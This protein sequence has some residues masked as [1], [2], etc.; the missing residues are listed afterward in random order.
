V[1]NHDELIMAL[2]ELQKQN[3]QVIMILTAAQNSCPFMHV[4]GTLKVT[5]CEI[6]EFMV[7]EAV[8]RADTVCREQIVRGV[9]DIKEIS[10]WMNHVYKGSPLMNGVQCLIRKEV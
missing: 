7:G 3:K 5:K 1:G 6:V 8:V 2:M 9:S 4:C 10:F